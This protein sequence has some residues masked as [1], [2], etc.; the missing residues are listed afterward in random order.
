MLTFQLEQNTIRYIFLPAT[1]VTLISIII[2]TSIPLKNLPKKVILVNWL[3]EPTLIVEIILSICVLVIGFTGATKFNRCW[4][5]SYSFFVGLVVIVAILS[6]S[7]V[8]TIT[9]SVDNIYGRFWYADYIVYQV[10][11]VKME[12]DCTNFSEGE[13]GTN[14][15]PHIIN[16]IGSFPDSAK[17]YV[18]ASL[19][20]ISL[21]FILNVFLSVFVSLK[22]DKNEAIQDEE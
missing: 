3:F 12:F 16:S 11:A 6:V 7:A 13:N 1:L 5:V 4:Q 20:I 22:E 19:I 8:K 9:S 14:C 2:T 18:T 15:R 17:R 10:E 21:Y